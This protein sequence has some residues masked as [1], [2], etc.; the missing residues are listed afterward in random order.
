MTPRCASLLSWTCFR[1]SD[2]E[3]VNE[4]PKLFQPQ[5][6]FR[7]RNHLLQPR[8]ILTADATNGSRVERRGDSRSRIRACN[9]PLI[10]LCDLRDAVFAIDVYDSPPHESWATKVT[11]CQMASILTLVKLS[12]QSPSIPRCLAS[13]A[14][15]FAI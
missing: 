11:S 2:A 5:L 12:A 10:F 15:K 14:R 1:R 3:A 4:P 13:R 6:A 9:I 8:D 7:R